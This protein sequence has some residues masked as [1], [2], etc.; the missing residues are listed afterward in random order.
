MADFVRAEPTPIDDLIAALTA[1]EAFAEA[2]APLGIPSSSQGPIL[3]L[4]WE[5]V[6]RG[7]PPLGDDLPDDG[8]GYGGG[9]VASLTD[10]EAALAEIGAIGVAAA[11]E[12]SAAKTGRVSLAMN[13]LGG[14]SNNQGVWEWLSWRVEACAR[15]A[16]YTGTEQ[17]RC[18]ELR[19][20]GYSLLEINRSSLDEGT[21]DIRQT[22][23]G[24][25][26]KPGGSLFD[27]CS[28]CG[29][30]LP[31]GSK[32]CMNC[33]K[34]RLKP[35][36]VQEKPAAV[37]EEC[38]GCGTVLLLDSKFCRNCGTK[39]EVTGPVPTDPPRVSTSTEQKR[40]PQQ[41]AF[42]GDIPSGSDPSQQVDRPVEKQPV[43]DSSQ[44][45]HRPAV[46]QPG[47][48]ISPQVDRPAEKQPV[49]DPSQQVDR[50][51][52]KQPVLDSSQQGHRPAV[53]QPGLGIPAQ[54]DRP[55]E[56]QP[57]WAPSQQ[58]DR[59]VENQQGSDMSQQVDFPEERRHD[60][61]EVQ[62]REL[63]LDLL[64]EQI[65][66][67]GMG[68]VEAE[69]FIAIC[70]ARLRLGISS[71]DAAD[72]RLLCEDVSLT[73]RQRLGK[74]EFRRLLSGRLPAEKM[75]FDDVVNHFLKVERLLKEKDSEEK[76]QRSSAISTVFDVW[77]LDGRGE[78][79][80]RRLLPTARLQARKP[81]H[82]PTG[83]TNH[84]T[85]RLL[86]DMSSCYA[87]PVSRIE[88][89]EFVEP[90]L[91]SD[92]VLFWEII[93]RLTALGT[94]VKEN[95]YTA[96]LAKSI[97]DSEEISTRKLWVLEDPANKF[98]WNGPFTARQVLDMVKKQEVNLEALVGGLEGP[99]NTPPQRKGAVA[100]GEALGALGAIARQDSA[101]R[102]RQ[103][104]AQQLIHGSRNPL[105]SPAHR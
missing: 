9:A 97:N 12:A 4:A 78:V 87:R 39:R 65:D 27:D 59:P 42:P 22:D 40:Y 62:R 46:E 49:W 47:L 76:Q 93:G 75:S 104:I 23:F 30:R 38:S 34:S 13:K 92:M 73:R 11:L 91:P 35:L 45:G 71:R 2:L 79:D 64:F 81:S 53:E 50:P 37:Q 1:L 103:D 31:G 56:K 6:R 80:C 51:V 28:N 72:M 41:V 96:T 105:R 83:W 74:A 69:Y 44:Q 101:Q 95:A 55:A 52:E 57:V 99:Q 86:E 88:M 29:S 77:N 10:E 36:A 67:K 94:E 63:Q 58:V 82:K 18:A 5:T 43:L 15:A 14:F 20:L 3:R 19:R 17:T 70:N 48:D 84:D 66:D 100:V 61:L 8:L 102:A 32:F 98:E 24:N 85:V 26:P 89:I 54:V 16:A 7:A 68:T 90:T 60:L 21:G 33:G 25:T